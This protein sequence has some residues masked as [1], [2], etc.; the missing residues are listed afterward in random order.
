M[1]EDLRF[2]TDIHSNTENIFLVYLILNMKSMRE[3]DIDRSSILYIHTSMKSIPA[4]K[5]R[6]PILQEE[7]SGSACFQTVLLCING[8][9]NFMGG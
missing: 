7:I 9:Y 2:S 5:K 6:N 4:E 8:I 3:W 1:K